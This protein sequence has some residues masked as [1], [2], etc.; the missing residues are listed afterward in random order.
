LRSNDRKPLGTTFTAG[1]RSESGR[2]GAGVAVMASTVE[3]GAV[4][5]GEGMA[6]VAP[7]ATSLWRK[8]RRSSA[9]SRAVLYRS[10]A[11]LASIFWQTRSNSRGIV[12]STCRGG[13]SS[14]RAISSMTSVGVA[15]RNGLRPVKSS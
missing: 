3:P 7:A 1:L 9:T 8:W 10:E 11:R 13:R 15:P 12:S 6:G 4:A 14:A 5:E 2:A